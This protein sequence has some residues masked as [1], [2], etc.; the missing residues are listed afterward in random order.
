MTFV[1]LGYLQI[2]D[3]VVVNVSYFFAFTD[4][5]TIDATGSKANIQ[6]G[7]AM[8]FAT[9]EFRKLVC[10]G[11]L[12]AEKVGKKKTPL[13]S[14]AY[15]YMFNACRVPRRE[16]DSYRIYDPSRYTHCIVARKG[17]FFAMEL[18]HPETGDPLP[19]SILEEQ[20]EE[21]VDLADAVPSSRPKLGLMTS[22][23]RDDWAD[24][25][26][27]L[28]STGGIAMEKALLKVESGAILLNLDDL[29]PVSRQECG[30]LFW[31]GGLNSGENRWFDKSIQIMVANNGK[32][33]FLGEH[34]MMD[35]MPCVNYCDYISQVRHADAKKRSGSGSLSISK[36]TDI[37]AEAL[38]KAAPA[39]VEGMETKGKHDLSLHSF[40]FMLSLT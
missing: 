3:P 6:R 5:P 30:E 28:L 39:V 24:A 15:K 23:N 26:G 19:V 14:A 33:G 35:G 7:A 36:V 29:A 38:D 11:Q 16:Q 18:V 20:L 32:A 8:L 1:Q 40:G 34:S 2:R 10:S 37:F 31:T 4:D 27:E 21:C 12:A 22:G 9:G 25:R 17:H 13:C